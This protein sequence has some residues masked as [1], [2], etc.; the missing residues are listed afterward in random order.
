[1]SHRDP[2]MLDKEKARHSFG[3][4]AAL[5]DETA[6]LQMEVGQRMLERLDYIRIEPQV[7]LD[8][9]CGTGALTEGLMRRYPRAEVVAL[10][11]A[12][13]MLL[14]TRQRGRWLR[15][16][17]CL[18]ADLDALPLADQSVDLVFANAALQWS[19][20]PAE[21]FA[22][23]ARVLKPG[24]LCMFS[25]F[26][27]DTLFELR[28]AWAEVDPGDHVHQFIDMHDYGDMLMAA[29]FADPVMDVERMTLTYG[30]AMQLMR[31]IKLIG[32]GNASRHRERGL[33]GRSR[34]ARV[35]AAYEQFRDADG[36]LPVTY[37]VVHGHAWGPTQRRVGGET[38]V[39]ID[40]L[41][42]RR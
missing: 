15:R 37:E 31:E 20:R 41:R 5:Y 13:P 14:R 2:P 29:G 34:I 27:P 6:V 16:P 24:G 28:A 7:I 35:C 3:R 25:S 10:D 32:A 39:A 26:G 40:V 8:I 11:F 38:R 9:G 30:D 1:M 22:D 23:I 42:T 21:T 36:R 17:R 18:C 12:L 33:V 4:A 19:A